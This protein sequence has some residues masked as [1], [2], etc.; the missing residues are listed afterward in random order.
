MHLL[1]LLQVL[2]LLVAANATPIVARRVLHGRFAYPLDAGIL[3]PD[4]RPLLG[5]SKT[6]R[7]IICSVL[8]TTACAPVIGLEWEV[9]FIVGLTA[10]MGDLLSSFFKR[11]LGMPESSMALGLDQIPESLFPLL[12]CRAFI[13]L[14]YVDVSVGVVIFFVCEIIFSKLSHRLGIRRHPY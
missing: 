5:K 11:R 13:P 8:L 3:L 4:G 2:A 14:T 7:G 10:M 9:G 6:I 1:P 12:A